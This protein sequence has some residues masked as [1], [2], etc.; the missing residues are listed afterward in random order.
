MKTTVKTIALVTMLTAASQGAVT[1]SGSVGPGFKDHLGVN[2]AAGSTCL[3]VVD[4][5]GNGFLNLA[6]TGAIGSS[7]SGQ[8]GKTITGAQAGLTIGSTFGGDYIL[9]TAVVGSGG[10]IGTLLSNVSVAGYTNAKFALVWFSG[11]VTAA[12]VAE[13]YFGELALTNWTLP[14]TDTG[15][16]TLNAAGT[17][18]YY[19]TG[20]STT[21]TQLGAGFFTGTGTAADT[22]S[23]AVRSAQFQVVP[24]PSA[25]LLGALGALGLLRRRR[26]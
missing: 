6:T 17:G 3:L 16:L 2:I 26:I 4:N 21:A 13:Q 20:T 5:G 18:T 25:A 12:N 15:T 10:S 9:N 19:A 11:V 23:T 8:T 22:G 1:I 14:S 24:E 7:L